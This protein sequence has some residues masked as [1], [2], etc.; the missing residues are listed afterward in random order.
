LIAADSSS[1]RRYLEGRL[2]RDTAAVDDALQNGQLRVAPVVILELLSDPSL[3]AAYVPQI[4]ALPDLEILKGHWQRA[5][6]LRG[7]L[8]R[9]VRRAGIADVLIA[10]SCLDHDIPLITYD[11]DFRHFE[12]VGLRLV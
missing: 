1:I 8:L 3:P 2:G 5:G 10:Q 7:D 9:S 11:R 6:A 4:H 12:R